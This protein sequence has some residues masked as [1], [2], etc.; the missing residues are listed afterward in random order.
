MQRTV[1]F[2]DFDS[3]EWTA[4]VNYGDGTIEGLTVVGRTVELDHL[5]DGA[6]TYTVSITITDNSS[7]SASASFTVTVSNE[8]PAVNFNLFSITSPVAEGSPVTLTGK[9][10]DTGL[11]ENHTIKIEW[12]DGEITTQ[13]LTAGAREFSATHTYADDT[14]PAG[15]VTPADVYRVKVSV[16][17][18][19]NLTDET[20]LGLLLAEVRNV[21]PFGLI[22]D[23]FA[24]S[25]D[26]GD[27]ITLNGS[28]SDPGIEDTHTLLVDWGDGTAPLTVELAAGVTTFS[29]LTHRYVD[30]QAVGADEYQL[31]ITVVDDDEPS[32]PAVFEQTISVANVAPVIEPASLSLLSAT[33]NENDEVTLTG[34]ILDPGI[35]DSQRIEINW[36]D[37][38]SPTVFNRKDAPYT[39]SRTHRYLDDPAVGSTFTISVRVIDNDMPADAVVTPSTIDVTVNNL[40]PVVASIE[41]RDLVTGAVITGPINEG[42]QVRVVGRITDVGILDKHTVM[43]D[44][45]D[46]SAPKPASVNNLNFTEGN[47]EYAA[48]FTAIHTY[49]DDSPGILVTVTDDD[50]GVGTASPAFQVNNLDPIVELAPDG[51]TTDPNFIKLLGIATDPGTLDIPDL[52][53]LW[54]VWD[55]AANGIPTA[56]Q[57]GSNP[58]FIINRTSFNNN[59][60]SVRL[61]VTDDDGGMGVFET[62]ILVGT[63]LADTLTVNDATLSAVGQT[64]LMVFGLGGEDVIDA[65]GVTIGNVILDGGA[66]KDVLF[67]GAG[68]DTYYLRGGDDSAN[69]AATINGVVVPVPVP[70]DG[71]SI[72]RGNDRY[73][74]TP[75]STLTV[76][77]HSGS[78]TLDFETATFGIKFDLG[79]TDGTMQN[80]ALTAPGTHIVSAD[81]SFSKLVGSSFGDELT[82]VAGSTV[83]GGGGDDMLKVENLSA[84]STTKLSGDDGAD[85]LVN[86]GNSLGTIEFSG[87]ADKDL[88][89]NV[90]SAVEIIFNGGA[91]D[92]TFMNASTG[93]VG[94]INF[95]GDDGI[96]IFENIGNATTI[97]FS[98]GA[99]NDVFMNASTGTVGTINFGGDDGID[100]F[101]NI[102]NAATIIFSGGADDDIFN[103][104]AVGGT[105]IDF[106][107]DDGIDT[108]NNAGTAT[109]I[110]FNG[111]ADDD[112]F[113]NT[114]TGTVEIRFGGDDGADEFN[115]LG[116]AGTIVFTGGADGDVFNNSGTATNITFNG[117]ADDDVFNNTITGSGTIIFSGDDGSDIFNNLG[118]NGTITFNGNADND[119]FNNSG[120]ATQI[121]FNGGADNDIFNNTST[122]AGAIEFGGDTGA[123]TFNNTGTAASILFTGGA[124]DDLL[125]NT[126]VAT[127]T[128]N[129]GGGADDDRFENYGTAGNLV[130]T[131]GADDDIFINAGTV[132][133]GIVFG[134][135]DGVDILLNQGR[136]YRHYVLRKRRWRCVYQHQF[137]RRSHHF[138][139]RPGSAGSSDCRSV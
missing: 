70:I 30:D 44:W 92:D 41:F 107:G 75:N 101:E 126:G 80:V 34:N 131:G 74:L 136:R 14:N 129:F 72:D 49:Q 95:G 110:I 55:G 40:D 127:G 117:G 12:G 58:D 87:G 138:Q 7:Q 123:D 26:E 22:V 10:S 56:T 32:N 130:F 112:V 115:N 52:T 5:Y 98:G 133:N 122:G 109:Q 35:R 114:S 48:S 63:N 31:K 86:S 104:S 85:T 111:G 37:G 139:R 71:G 15:S 1:T 25:I 17:D 59:V 27:Q 128:I 2:E 124:D 51:T 13:N 66:D 96:D 113:N 88:F 57:T 53:Y 9:F 120:T 11:T 43:I 33:I 16:I 118:T 36:G 106:A 19:G 90:G 94:T 100:T 61:T 91:D 24:T 132:T 84:A 116:G 102:G 134:G 69:V 29:G 105:V 50:G 68:D 81:G 64:N 6:D 82:A 42:Q 60:F 93:T 21:A 39:F 119:I 79:L 45:Q 28:F 65:S 20:P 125:T 135:D 73:V 89:E 121:K 54:E 62:A 83:S 4:R 76:V 103:N 46:G 78:N 38:S 47:V 8:A 108:F 99:D 97:V 23:P 77:D 18:A 137:G 67:G 3:T